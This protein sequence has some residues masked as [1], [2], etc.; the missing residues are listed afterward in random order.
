MQNSVEQVLPQQV[1]AKSQAELGGNSFILKA[2]PLSS[3]AL[4]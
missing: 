4:H 2:V 1:T 3:T